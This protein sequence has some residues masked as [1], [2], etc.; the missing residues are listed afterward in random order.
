[1]RYFILLFLLTTLG[2]N[3]FKPNIKLPSDS[4]SLIIKEVTIPSKGYYEKKIMKGNE[5]LIVYNNTGV[6]P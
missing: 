2:C 6:S 5:P 1:M 3:S 4:D